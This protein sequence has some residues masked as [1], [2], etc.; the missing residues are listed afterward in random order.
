MEINYFLVVISY[1]EIKQ[2]GSGEIS[3]P[4]CTKNTVG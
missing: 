2:V 3:I 1:I 4:L